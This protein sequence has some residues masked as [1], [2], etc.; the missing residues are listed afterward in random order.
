MRW[1]V[2]FPV[3]Y[4]RGAVYIVRGGS[5]LK[6]AAPILDLAA[7]GTEGFPDEFKGNVAQ[8]DP[9]EGSQNYHFG[10]TVQLA[11]LDGNSRA[12]V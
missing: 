11:D 3:S 7:F 5:Y 4:N 6:E 12:Y 10:G 1:M 9:P 2:G 8:I